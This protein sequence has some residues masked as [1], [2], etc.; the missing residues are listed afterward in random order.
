MGRNFQILQNTLHDHCHVL[1]GHRADLLLERKPFK[2][3]HHMLD[4]QT[5]GSAE[6]YLVGQ[7]FCASLRHKALQQVLLYCNMQ[8]INLVKY[9]N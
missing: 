1:T 7:Q 2:F 9:T 5:S 3:L 8:I 4:N 6:H